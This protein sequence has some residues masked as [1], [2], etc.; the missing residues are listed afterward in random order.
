MLLFY[1]CYYQII[2]NQKKSSLNYLVL[3]RIKVYD[4]QDHIP[5]GI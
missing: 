5:K 1:Y 4:I 3:V 2:I